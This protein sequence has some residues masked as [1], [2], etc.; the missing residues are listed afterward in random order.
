M[1]LFIRK[2]L[3]LVQPRIISNEEMN[4][5]MKIINSLYIGVSEGIRNEGKEQKGRLE[6]Y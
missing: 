2:C 6:I 3:D 5:I 4:D 1:Q